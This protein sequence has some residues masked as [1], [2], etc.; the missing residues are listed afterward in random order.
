VVA[1][2]S[3]VHHVLITAVQANKVTASEAG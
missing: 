1:K 3:F 2:L